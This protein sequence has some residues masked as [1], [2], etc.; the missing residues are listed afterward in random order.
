MTLFYF[1]IPVMGRWPVQKQPGAREAT[2]A[3]TYYYN[4]FMPALLYLRHDVF[5]CYFLH[6]VVGENDAV[7]PV[8]Q[9][10]KPLVEVGVQLLP[11]SIGYDHGIGP[12]GHL[13]LLVCLPFHSTYNNLAIGQ[14]LNTNHFVTLVKHLSTV[15]CLVDVGQEVIASIVQVHAHKRQRKGVGTIFVHGL[16]NGRDVYQVLEGFQRFVDVLLFTFFL[17]CFGKDIVR[18]G[19]RSLVLII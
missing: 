8:F 12:K 10:G 3:S 2:R 6:K 9:G 17:G 7:L 14:K 18:V 1:A 19:L 11:A 4:V 15:V 16:K 5:V 13:D